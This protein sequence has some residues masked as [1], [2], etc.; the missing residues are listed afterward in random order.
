MLRAQGRMGL[1]Q[2]DRTCPRGFE[3]KKMRGMDV[4]EG[5]AVT[6]GT[7]SLLVVG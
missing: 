2:G 6:K 5:D 4:A 7:S 3:S 1:D